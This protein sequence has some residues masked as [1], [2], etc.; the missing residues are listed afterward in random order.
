[1]GDLQ[2]AHIVSENFPCPMEDISI[3]VERRAR[4][5]VLLEMEA[6]DGPERNDMSG[7]EEPNDPVGN[8]MNLN[9]WQKT[10]EET[11][12]AKI[13]MNQL[14]TAAGDERKMMNAETAFT[15]AKQILVEETHTVTGNEKSNG[16]FLWRADI[17]GPEGGRVSPTNNGFADSEE[18]R[19][20]EEKEKMEDFDRLRSKLL[21]YG[22]QQIIYIQQVF[23]MTTTE[24]VET[25][26]REN[27]N[28]GTFPNNTGKEIVGYMLEECSSDCKKMKKLGTLSCAQHASDGMT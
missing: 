22:L 24:L 3:A 2:L 5:K 7:E 21:K 20:A 28:L 12:K 1:M 16:L 9:E 10:K 8:V 25:I 19:T 18:E 23:N 17:G 6:E 15:V 11:K 26:V 14:Q 4:A 27:E 13:G